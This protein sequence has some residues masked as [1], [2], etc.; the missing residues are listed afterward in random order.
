MKG[1]SGKY[2]L[3]LCAIGEYAKFL[4]MEENSLGAVDNNIC[5]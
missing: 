2:S 4:N 1:C 3:L 5:V